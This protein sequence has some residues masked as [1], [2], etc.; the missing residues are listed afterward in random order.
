[1]HGKETKGITYYACS[2]RITYGDKAADALGHGKWQYLREDRL[3]PL[4]DT[5]FASRV[6]GP[7]RLAHFKSQHRTLSREVSRDTSADRDRIEK[8]LAAIDQ[9]LARQMAAIEADVD[10]LIVGERIRELKHERGHIEAAYNDLVTPKADAPLPFAEASEI[11][12]NLPNLQPA[13]AAAAPEL[14]RQVYDA[15]RLRV[16]IDRN[17]GL[18]TLKALVSSAF[19]DASNLD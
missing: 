6:F 15:F 14:R 12:D 5:F 9:R 17:E 13:L 2:Y 10:P 8:Q 11:L 7:Q 3:L 19:G 16:E 1:M 18:V 4:I